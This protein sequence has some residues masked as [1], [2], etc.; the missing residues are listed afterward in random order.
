MENIFFNP[1][2]IVTLK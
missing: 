1:G 2:D